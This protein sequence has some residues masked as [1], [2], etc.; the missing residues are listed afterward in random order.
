MSPDHPRRLSQTAPPT[1]RYFFA[2]ASTRPD[3]QLPAERRIS[4][5]LGPLNE[6]SQIYEFSTFSTYYDREMGGP[7]YKYFVARQDLDSVDRLVQIKLQTERIE[8]NLAVEREGR[9]VR[10]VNIDPGYVTSW[11]VILATVKNH[12]HRIYLSDGIYAEVTLLFRGGRFQ[13]LPW[14][15]PDYREDLALD[16]FG[17]LRS[18]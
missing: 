2:I 11:N 4:D 9:R 14:T 7:V 13:T 15:Y 18:Q 1:A 6:R 12:S 3:V 10:C 5:I 8:A 17:K 16:F